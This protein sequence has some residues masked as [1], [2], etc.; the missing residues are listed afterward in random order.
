MK[1]EKLD[2][3][4]KKTKDAKGDCFEEGQ[5]SSSNDPAAAYSTVHED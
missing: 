5:V 1:T 3:V 4:K 2:E